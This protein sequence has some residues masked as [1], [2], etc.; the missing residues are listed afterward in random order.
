[1]AAELDN[2]PA[3]SD[4]QGKNSGSRR[5]FRALVLPFRV[6]ITVPIWVYQKVIS[7]AIPPHCIYTPS[8]SEY[9]RRAVLRHGFIGL[10]A[11][12]LRLGRCVGALYDGGDDEVPE[13]LTVSYLFGSYRTRWRRSRR[14]S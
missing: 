1:M 14:G 6:L 9:T 3:E 10:L 2:D 12:I 8:C 5:V 7:P 13:R 11:G 4:H